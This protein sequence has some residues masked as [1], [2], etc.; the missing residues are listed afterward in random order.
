MTKNGLKK[1]FLK[2]ANQ[3]DLINKLFYNNKKYKMEI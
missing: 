1:T 2:F 3:L